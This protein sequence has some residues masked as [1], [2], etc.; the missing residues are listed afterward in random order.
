MFHCKA[1]KSQLQAPLVFT[2]A[3][4]NRCSRKA[5]LLPVAKAFGMKRKQEILGVK[6]CCRLL[7]VSQSFSHFHFLVSMTISNT[8]LV[9]FPA[10]VALTASQWCRPKGRAP[11]MGQGKEVQQCLGLPEG[12]IRVKSRPAALNFLRI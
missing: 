5:L 6:C 11:P 4:G 8:D 1:V 12:L 2:L 3:F 10:S 9:I 7:V